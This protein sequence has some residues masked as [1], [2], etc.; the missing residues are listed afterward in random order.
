[1]DIASFI[2]A[3]D[4]VAIEIRDLLV[5]RLQKGVKVRLLLDFA[6]SLSTS[7][8][9]FDSFE[10]FGGQLVYFNK[11][12]KIPKVPRVDLRNHR[13]LVIRDRKDAMAGG[14]NIG[15]E[16][17]GPKQDPSRWIDLSFV[18][19][20]PAV[21]ALAR[22]FDADW[23]YATGDPGAHPPLTTPLAQAGEGIV[24]VVP[25]GPDTPGDPLY[26][27]IITGIYAATQRLWVVTP[28]FVPDAPMV[29]AIRNAAYK[30][31]DVRLVV[32]SSSDSLLMDLARG[33][34][35]RKLQAAGVKILIHSKMVHAKVIVAD[36]CFAVIGSANMDV[37]SFFLNYEAVTFFYSQPE[38]ES[39][40]AW[41]EKLFDGC[42]TE[43][44]KA[45]RARIMGEGLVRLL[46]P[47]L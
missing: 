5:A 42:R 6:G 4:E 20:G 36:N 26:N 43:V 30:G 23:E 35:M 18:T 12:F 11:F 39:T 41:V 21:E 2:F 29:T 34:H 16:Y 47:L 33:H 9:F 22:I 27:S 25:S 44:L 19:Q 1:L 3:T 38:I 15:G 13:K 40:A 14:R 37:R 31:V 8:G 32:P 45:S 17:L 28:Y 10:R 7:G 46:E 24:Q